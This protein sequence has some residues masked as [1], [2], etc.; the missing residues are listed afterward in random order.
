[1]PT[2]RGKATIKVGTTGNRVVFDVTGPSGHRIISELTR[3]ETSA[4][5]D[6]IRKAAELTDFTEELR[7]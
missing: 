2:E 3:T 7:I 4:L 6:A 5:I 1:M